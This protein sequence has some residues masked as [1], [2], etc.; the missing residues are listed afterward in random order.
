MVDRTEIGVS[1][2]RSAA[3]VATSALAFAFVAASVADA[4]T[5][6]KKDRRDAADVNAATMMEQGRETFRNDSFG[7]ED[8]WGGAL[9][10]HEAIE[11]E[12]HGGVGPGL[13]PRTALAVGLK[14]DSDALSPA[15]VKRIQRG[16]VD[17]D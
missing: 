12:S 16:K 8:F 13:T 17:L 7:S 14:V 10:L 9:R 15:L 3:L 6:E 1:R 2:R 11:G 5:A 4:I